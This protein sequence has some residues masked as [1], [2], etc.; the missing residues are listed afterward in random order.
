MKFFYVV[1]FYSVMA[2]SQEDH[3]IKEARELAAD[4]KKSLMQNLSEKISK[5]GIVEAVPFC[6][7]NVKTIAKGAAKKRTEKFEFGRTSHKV[8]NLANT[9]QS[10]A[11]SYVKEFEGKMKGEVKKD[12]ILHRLENNKRV[13][14]EPLYVEAKCLLCHG[15]NVSANV[16]AKVKELYP[17]DKATGFKLGEFRG[18]IWVKEK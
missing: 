13:Y 17:E 7:A 16:L 11:V 6:H 14:M 1:I 8:R 2:L 9:P 4:L 12:Q 5:D 15:E 10:W 18:F 3:F